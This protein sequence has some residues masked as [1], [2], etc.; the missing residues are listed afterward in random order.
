MPFRPHKVDPKLLDFARVMRHEPAPAEQK[1]WRCLRDRQLNG[2]K[3]RRQV[4]V[5][6]YIADFYCAACRLVVE[7]DGDSHSDRKQYDEKRTAE[8]EHEGLAVLRFVNTD[9]FDHLD[10]VL[11]AILRECEAR[12]SGASGRGPSPL[13]SPLGTG[14][15][16]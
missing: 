13:P 3:F 1:L 7:L 12:I 5:G 14:E 4:A 2:F 11:E 16:G 6:T 8:L 10:S 15:R 9:V